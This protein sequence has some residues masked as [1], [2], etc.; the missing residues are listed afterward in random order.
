M[1]LCNKQ[2]LLSQLSAASLEFIFKF[3]H[4]EK[5]VFS[6][7]YTANIA[8]TL[9]CKMYR[10]RTLLDRIVKHRATWCTF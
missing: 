7:L 5:N 2:K 10:F 9:M 4:F 1:E 6:K 8:I 3:H